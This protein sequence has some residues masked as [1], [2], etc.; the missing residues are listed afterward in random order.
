MASDL[1]DVERCRFKLGN[2]QPESQGIGR[3][4]QVTALGERN[5]DSL[6]PPRSETQERQLWEELELLKRT[7]NVPELLQRYYD[8]KGLADFASFLQD[9][10]DFLFSKLKELP[11]IV[12]SQMVPSSRGAASYLVDNLETVGWAPIQ[13]LLS[14]N[15]SDDIALEILETLKGKLPPPDQIDRIKTV[16]PAEQQKVLGLFRTIPPTTPKARILAE[17]VA[18]ICEPECISQ[19]LLDQKSKPCRIHGGFACNRPIEKRGYFFIAYDSRNTKFRDIV[20]NV[21]EV[22]FPEIKGMD[23]E[24]RFADTLIF[25]KVCEM[26][27]DAK[28]CVFD[29]SGDD[30]NERPNHNVMLELGVAVCVATPVIMCVKKGTRDISDLGGIEKIHYANDDELAKKLHDADFSQLLESR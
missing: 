21:I 6:M 17:I 19:L 18:T 14:S 25:C 10:S 7:N 1:R 22:R 15:I 27:Q 5:T 2:L 8:W 30:R 4:I 16:R 11:A 3:K 9:I 20:R 13:E 28:F 12:K 29:I 26:I 23:Y 24:D